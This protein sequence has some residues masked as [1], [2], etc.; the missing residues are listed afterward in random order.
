MPT[1]VDLSDASLADDID[2]NRL[3]RILEQGLGKPAG[4]ILPLQFQ[5]WHAT[6]RWESGPWET[7]TDK[8]YLLPGDSPMGLRLPLQTLSRGEAAQEL[9]KNYLPQDPSQPRSELVSPAD[10]RYRIQA[11]SMAVG[12]PDAGQTNN[13]AE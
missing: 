4:C 11:R 1:N 12:G 3:A 13:A 8:V 5:T 9:D 10:V 2:R 6:P 7:R